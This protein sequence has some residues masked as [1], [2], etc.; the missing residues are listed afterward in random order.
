[1][2]QIKWQQKD[3]HA[4]MFLQ[5]EICPYLNDVYASVVVRSANGVP[6]ESFK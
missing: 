5:E 1:M 4:L 3:H 2:C 6:I